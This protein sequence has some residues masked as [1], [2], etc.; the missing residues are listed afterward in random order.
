M[1]GR[2]PHR[3][4]PAT[5]EKSDGAVRSFA[6]DCMQAT[7]VKMDEDHV[8]CTGEPGRCSSQSLRS[9]SAIRYPLS[10]IRYPLSA[11]RYP[12]SAI[13]HPPSAI[14]PMRKLACALFGSGHPRS[15]CPT[16]TTTALITRR[17][18]DLSLHLHL[19][20]CG[21]RLHL[22]TD[23]APLHLHRDCLVRPRGRLAPAA[24]IASQPGMWACWHSR[25]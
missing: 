19:H 2:L 10:A 9:L 5:G 18:S 17:D 15:L 12:L 6:S 21:A 3:Q 11:I 16:S 24:R 4:R 23:T 1:A 22:V 14:A 8:P 7:P 13:R 25:L 20:L